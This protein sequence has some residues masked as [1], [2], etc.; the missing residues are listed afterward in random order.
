MNLIKETYF[1]SNIYFVEKTNWVNDYVK[2][3]DPYIL[4]AKKNVKDDIGISYHSAPLTKDENF[5]E[6]KI[7]ICEQSK[8]I[9][10]EQGYDL[11]NYKFLV[12]DLW[13]QEFSER[14]G[15]HHNSHVHSNTHINGF[16]FLKCSP[17]TSYPIFHDP[18]LYKRIIDLDQ[19]NINLISDASYE[20]NVK[21]KNGLLIFFNSYL[22]HQFV[23]DK[24]IDPFRFIHFNI[25]VVPNYC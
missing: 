24:G 19:K 9:L 15:G 22:E 23:V 2:Y 21:P 1:S 13:V 4:D 11:K 3:T 20:I 7:F 17:N 8:N 18:R 6:L 5:N 12:K 10:N 25:Q 16:F 14:G